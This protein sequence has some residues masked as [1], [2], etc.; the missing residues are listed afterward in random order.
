MSPFERLLE[1]LEDVRKTGPGRAIAKC[2][3]HEDRSPSLTVNELDDGKVLIHCFAGCDNESVVAAVGMRMADLFPQRL[4]DARSKPPRAWLDAR[5]ALA[6]LATECQVIA[7][8][9]NDIAEGKP[10]S[11]QDADRIAVAAG[12]IRRAREVSRGYY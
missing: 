2:P 4:A 11:P 8:A 6:C 9:A 7:I 12:R 1:R 5:D 10:I 3:A